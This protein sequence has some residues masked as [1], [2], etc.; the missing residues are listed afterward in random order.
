VTATSESP[1]LPL[2][3]GPVRREVGHELEAALLELI[4]LSLLGKQLHWSLSGHTRPAATWQA[5]QAR[6]G[7]RR[8]ILVDHVPGVAGGAMPLEASACTT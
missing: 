2:L 1:D 8:T 3:G 6:P 5:K 4:D 7:L